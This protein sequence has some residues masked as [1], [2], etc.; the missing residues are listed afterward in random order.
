MLIAIDTDH[1]NEGNWNDDD[2]W[3][4]WTSK[5]EFCLCSNLGGKLCEIVVNNLKGRWKVIFDEKCDRVSECVFGVEIKSSL[6]D[7]TKCDCDIFQCKVDDV[8]TDN[9]YKIGIFTVIGVIA[10]SARILAK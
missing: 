5:C 4:F 6:S 1:C 10:V 9:G 2:Y 7:P 3:R 8:N